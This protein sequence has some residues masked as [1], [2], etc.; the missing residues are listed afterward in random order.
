MFASIYA[1][2]NI[3]DTRY[4]YGRHYSTL[5]DHEK[6]LTGKWGFMSGILYNLTIFFVKF[7]IVLF[8][9]RIG[10]LNRW[11]RLIIYLDL[12]LVFGSLA[13][14]VIVQLVQC[15]PINHNWNPA[16]GGQCLPKRTL[17]LV[18]YISSGR[19]TIVEPSRE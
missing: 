4:G 17:T 15:R 8:L 7:S 1:A 10:K 2:S 3:V 6:F 12:A 5:S 14:A 18:S 13:T 16:V 19:S 9:L 11:I